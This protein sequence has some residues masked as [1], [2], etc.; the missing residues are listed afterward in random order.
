MQS[1]III[2]ILF[3]YR[4][5][6]TVKPYLWGDF[7]TLLSLCSKVSAA[8]QSMVLESESSASESADGT[9]DFLSFSGSPSPRLPRLISAPLL[10]NCVVSL[11]F[12]ASTCPRTPTGPSIWAT[13]GSDIVPT[14]LFFPLYT[15]LR[16]IFATCPST[17]F[18]SLGNSITRTGRR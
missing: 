2:I 7:T 16:T 12:T 9:A 11:L 6:S 15:G 5:Y 4:T 1:Y 18:V 10:H 14:P 13:F 17:R 8:Y 3:S